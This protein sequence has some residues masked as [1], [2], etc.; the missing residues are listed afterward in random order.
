[1]R[2]ELEQTGYMRTERTSTEGLLTG[3]GRGEGEEAG[4][5]HS[6]E[7]GRIPRREMP[8]RGI[9]A[10]LFIWKPFEDGLS[11]FFLGVPWT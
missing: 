1:M 11:G 5:G 4:G 9:A 3:G 7:K 8:T 10:Q 2:S 6:R